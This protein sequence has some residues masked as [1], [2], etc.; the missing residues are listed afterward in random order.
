MKS[1]AYYDGVFGERDEIRVP[2]SDRAIFFGDAV[3]EAAIGTQSRIFLLEEHI[4]RFYKNI[5]RLKIP[6]ETKKEQLVKIL[7]DY[8]QRSGFS[9][10][11]LY[12]QCSRSSEERRHSYL[13]AEGCHLLITV[14]YFTVSPPTRVLRLIS[15][16]DLRY[17]YCDIKTVNLLPA[18][19]ASG[20]AE[21]AGC[22]EAVLY[23]GEWVTECAHSNISILK[24]GRIFSH[25]TDS[26]ILPG[27]SRRQ[28]S[29]VAKELGVPFIEKRFTLS[30]CF[31]ADEIIVTS[32]SR[33][34][35]VASELDGIQVGGR[36]GSIRD[37][38]LEIIYSRYLDECHRKSV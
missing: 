2:L 6:F 5:A 10:Y 37:R 15:S 18:V 8:I 25:P 33:L 31:S 20:E 12:F 14:D 36:G 22:D 7:Y 1:Y 4:E 16:E 38:I 3:Y 32:T 27:I 28:L 11:F 13:S 23:R 26:F 17:R 35:A 29:I 34:C 30:D 19:L 9:E 21:T 24:D